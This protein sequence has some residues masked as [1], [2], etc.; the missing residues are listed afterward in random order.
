ARRLPQARIAGLDPSPQMLAL[1]ERK[2]AGRGLRDRVA[3]LRGDALSLPFA[4]ASCAAV[5]SAF[6]LRNLPNLPQALRE[7]RRV[8]FPG[9]PVL[10]LELAWP[11]TPIFRA[12]FRLYFT[13][14][15]PAL[16]AAV[17]GSRRAYTY[18]PASVDAFLRPQ[19]LAHTMEEA[20]LRQVRALRLFPGTATIHLGWR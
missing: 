11:Q 18:L 6:V 12:I 1:G 5:V 13:R 15:V 4:E 8:V 17:A 19:A 9:G 7:M 2:L 14:L 3:L 20:G 16:G 10:C